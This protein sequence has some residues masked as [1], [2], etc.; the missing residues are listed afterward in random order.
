MNISVLR[1]ALFIPFEEVKPHDLYNFL[2]RFVYRII[3]PDAMKIYR[4]S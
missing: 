2:S 3:N 4:F 1:G